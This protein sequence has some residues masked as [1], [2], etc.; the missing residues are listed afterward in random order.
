[1]LNIPSEKAIQASGR[2]AARTSNCE[3]EFEWV[4]H[5]EYARAAGLS[6]D[7]IAAVAKPLDAGSWSASERALLRA[8]D[9]LNIDCDISE[10]T[11]AQLLDHFDQPAL[12]EIL[13]VVGQYTMQVTLDGRPTAAARGSLTSGRS[14][15]I[16]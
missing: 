13:F 3:S 4:E 11:W 14:I 15:R 6:D 1:M 8:A 16:E 7:E 9:E 10:A 2:A 12:V 5:T